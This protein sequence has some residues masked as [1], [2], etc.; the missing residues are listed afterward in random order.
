MGTSLE[1]FKCHQA[2]S[3]EKGGGKA[4]I[5]NYELILKYQYIHEIDKTN[6]FFLIPFPGKYCS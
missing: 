1:V 5:L 6:D 4:H 3:V 2:I